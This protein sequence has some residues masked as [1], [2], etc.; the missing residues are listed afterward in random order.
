MKRIYLARDVSQAQ[1]IVNLLEQQFIPAK[2]ENSHQS[3][4]LGELAVSFPEVWV[5]RQGDAARARSI[6]DDF[7]A[8]ADSFAADKECT[9]CGEQNPGNFECCWACMAELH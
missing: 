9:K 2:I 3:S 6:I 7:E 5:T 4:G 8:Q 1:L